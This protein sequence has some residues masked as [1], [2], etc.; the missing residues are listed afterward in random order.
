MAKMV[1][2]CANPNDFAQVAESVEKAAGSCTITY[3]KQHLEMVYAATS[4]SITKSAKII[5]Q[6]SD[7]SED[8][9]RMKIHRGLNKIEHDVQQKSKPPEI[10]E[11]TT[12]EIIKGRH[13]QGGG[14]REGAGRK[15]IPIRMATEAME[16]ATMAKT[17]LECI[18]EDD[19]E[20]EKALIYIKNWINNQLGGN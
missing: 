6:D 20:R 19:P 13:P 17:N 15:K 5:S 12:P 7:E 9:V 14:R 3:A 8:A 16:F 2:E 18:R 10:V 1:I 11:D 4:K